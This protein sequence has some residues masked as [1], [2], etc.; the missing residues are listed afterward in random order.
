M[1]YKQW[2]KQRGRLYSIALAWLPVQVN[3]VHVRGY[4]LVHLHSRP[5]TVSILL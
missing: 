4:Y 3:E 2:G 1:N 5:L